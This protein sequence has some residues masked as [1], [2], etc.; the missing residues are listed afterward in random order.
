M[1]KL[2]KAVKATWHPVLT[3]KQAED[4]DTPPPPTLT[5]DERPLGE[6]R[7]SH[8]ESSR[9]SGHPGSMARTVR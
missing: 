3:V 7:S 5:C 1:V 6:V 9:H 8:F 4:L 2:I